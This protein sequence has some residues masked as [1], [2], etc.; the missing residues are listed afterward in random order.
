M[1]IATL[2]II[3]K[4]ENNQDELIKKLSKKQNKTKLWYI[5]AKQ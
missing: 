1:F 2:V 4:L 5:K 3:A